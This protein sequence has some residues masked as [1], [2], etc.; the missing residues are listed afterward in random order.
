[1]FDFLTS[2]SPLFL[3]IAGII[4]TLIGFL[5]K[6]NTDLH[7]KNA[8]AEDEKQE[9]VQDNLSLKTQAISTINDLKKQDEIDA[10]TPITPDDVDNWLH[11][12]SQPNNNNNPESDGPNSASIPLPD[13]TSNGWVRKGMSKRKLPLSLRMVRKTHDIWKEIKN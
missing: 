12:A 9:L 5:W 1:M 7:E 10:N 8:V 13:S 11:T 3:F 4:T 2:F 6:S